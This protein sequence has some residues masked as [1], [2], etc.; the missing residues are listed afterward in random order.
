MRFLKVRYL[1]VVSLFILIFIYYLLASGTEV[2]RYKGPYGMLRKM[3][4]DVKYNLKVIWIE[5]STPEE[6]L[7]TTKLPVYSIWVKPEKLD[8][9]NSNLPLSGRNTSK[10]NLSIWADGIRL[11]F[12]IAGICRGIGAPARSPGE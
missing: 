1:V 5:L 8:I 4:D 6:N 3:R 10:A 11:K 2:T 9:L 7:S 12:D